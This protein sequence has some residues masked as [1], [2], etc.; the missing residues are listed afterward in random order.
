MAERIP[1]YGFFRA[2]GLAANSQGHGLKAHRAEPQP[3][4]KSKILL[5]RNE[6]RVELSRYQT[7][8]GLPLGNFHITEHLNLLAQL[9]NRALFN[10]HHQPQQLISSNLTNDPHL[11][12]KK[13]RH[14]TGNEHV[15]ER[16]RVI[17]GHS[18][19]NRWAG[20]GNVIAGHL[21]ENR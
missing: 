4:D 20:S 18:C 13:V 11:V 7:L 17:A 3:V 9:T 10:Q 8:N 16:S 14:L 1:R 2:L 21:C 5:L 6:H 12:R 15:S 19:E